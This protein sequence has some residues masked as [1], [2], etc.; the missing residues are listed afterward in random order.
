MPARSCKA[1][2]AAGPERQAH[3]QQKK[4]RRRRRRDYPPSETTKRRK[5][6]AR[7]EARKKLALFDTEE[8]SLKA[9]IEAL[10]GW[11]AGVFNAHGNDI[12]VQY[13]T[14][15][16]AALSLPQRFA[17]SPS[18]SD[19]AEWVIVKPDAGKAG[20]K[21]ARPCCEIEAMF[22]LGFGAVDMT[23]GVGQSVI[24]AKRYLEFVDECFYYASC[25]RPYYRVALNH[26]E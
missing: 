6:K 19:A 4:A 9:Q 11:E 13:K 20:T 2:L 16:A 26:G 10:Q 14:V 15:D 17:S 1:G 24:I 8:S 7:E 23:R 18:L 21:L 22:G 5:R 3:K 25:T 12:H